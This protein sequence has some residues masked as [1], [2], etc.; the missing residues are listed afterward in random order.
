MN[1]AAITHGVGLSFRQPIARNQIR[2]AADGD[3]AACTLV[4]WKR[5]EPN[6][7]RALKMRPRYHDGVKAEWIC[8]AAFPEEAHYIKYFF[9]LEDG[10]GQA[11]YFCEHGFSEREPVCG[12]FEALQTFEDDMPHAPA[13]SIGAVYYQIFPE[14]FAS[15][16][17]FKALRDYAPWD[18]R[19]TRDIFLG[20]DLNGIR[21]KL[22]YLKSLGVQ[23]LYLTPPSAFATGISGPC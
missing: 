7:R 13:W 11:K 4:L 20:G 8:D 16:S 10:E 12:F 23:C 15:G 22:P 3:L 1:L 6:S 14:R 2:L 9:R 21:E 18:A 5:S 19:P 17:P